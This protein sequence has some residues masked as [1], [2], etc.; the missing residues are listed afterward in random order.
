MEHLEDFF[1][2]ITDQKAVRVTLPILDKGEKQR[3]SCLFVSERQPSFYL[4]FPPGNLPATRID[5]QRTC[6]VTVDFGGQ[7]VSLVAE[8]V[9]IDADQIIHATARELVSHEQNRSYFRVD[10]ATP[11]AAEP[12]DAALQED[13]DTSW[14]LIGETI[15]LSGSGMLCLFEAPIEVDRK[16]RVQLT[17]PT[18]AMDVLEVIGHVV[19]CKKNSD[20]Q[21][22]IALHFDNIAIEEQDRII[23]SCLEL[24]RKQLRM[25]VQVQN[26]L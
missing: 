11:V 10:A 19:R 16:V 22:Q 21:Y 2:K 15:D 23:G 12:L 9:S 18:G 20:S 7:A 26:I 4:V 14:R 17:L 25:K 8:I 5:Q 3:F 6:V 24:Q 13:A 1:A